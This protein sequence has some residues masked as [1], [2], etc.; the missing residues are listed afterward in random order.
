MSII[1]LTRPTRFVG[2]VLILIC[3]LCQT[4]VPA[5]EAAATMA[6]RA[7]PFEINY[8]V[9]FPRPFTH[10][11]EVEMRVAGEGR[12]NLPR[13]LDLI[14]PVWTPGS[15]LI[16]EYARNVQDFQVGAAANPERNFIWRK[17]NKN[18]WRV[19]VPPDTREVRITYR[20]YANELTVRTNELNDRHAFWN[21]AALL[22][23]PEGALGSPSTL[24]VVPF[25]DWRV[26]TGLPTVSG[27][28]NTFRA[29]NYDILYDSPFEVGN[30]RAIDFTV[31]GVP[32]RIIIEGAGNYDAELLRRDVSRIVEA[33]VEMM[34]EIPYRDYTFLLNL[35]QG[36][37]GGLEHLNSTALISSPFAFRPAANYQKFLTLVAHEYFHLWNVKRLRPDA[38]GPF[39]YTRENYTRLLWMAEG[40]TSYF[41]EMLVRRAGLSTDKD[42]LTEFAQTIQRIEN[43]PGRRQMSIEE[44]SFDAWI[45]YYRPDENAVNSQI[46]YYEK[47]GIVAL[48]LD[49]EIRNRSRGAHSLDDVLR[50]LY[51]EFYK[52]GRNY[53]PE[54]LQRLAE[55]FAGANLEQF[56][57]S[58]VR[59]RAAID[60]NAALQPFGLRLET[61]GKTITSGAF[62]SDDLRQDGDRLTIVRVVEGTPA[63]EQG[64]NSGDQ[65]IALD[66]RRVTRDTLPARLAEK[67]P[68]DTIRLTVFRFDELRTFEIKLGQNP[69]PAPY[70]IVPIENPSAEQKRLYQS[71]MRQ[72]V[73]Q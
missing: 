44:A 33:A 57:S 19:D 28:P 23:Y 61:S 25:A 24:R 34:G 51:T 15:Y 46:S 10:L 60:Y 2:T 31:R 55:R 3:I 27:Q 20:V 22:M 70:R 9:S 32:H 54:D 11:L 64:L 62:F 29:E 63:Y 42:V 14:M 21:N 40:G 1:N 30:F 13:S 17:I 69:V 6:R 16:R 59:G 67:Q 26:A 43:A 53:T 52:Q 65:I 66:D 36:G 50:A 18:T 7:A 49:L 12:A 48:L 56:F 73:T 58:Y 4:S 45:K 71:W 8:T 68:G 72:S 5:Q 38:L 47:G 35:R 39:D 41:E 37:G